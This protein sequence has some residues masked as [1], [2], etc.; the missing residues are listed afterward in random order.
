[1]RLFLLLFFSIFSILNLS[2]QRADGRI[3]LQVRLSGAQEVPSPVNTKAKSLVTIF[4][5]ED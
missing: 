2:A 1:M 3:M 4:I 5:E